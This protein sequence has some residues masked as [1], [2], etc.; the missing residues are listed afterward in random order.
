MIM[1]WVFLGFFNGCYCLKI[2]IIII[3]III[4]VIICECMCCCGSFWSSISNFWFVTTNIPSWANVVGCLTLTQRR[5]VMGQLSGRIAGQ[6]IR[7]M[8]CGWRCAITRWA[9]NNNNNMLANMPHWQQHQCNWMK[10]KKKMTPST[11][12][13]LLFRLQHAI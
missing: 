11:H 1:G 9:N 12:T 3:I 4:I 8:V 6:G 5:P 2:I 7:Q 10:K 13:I